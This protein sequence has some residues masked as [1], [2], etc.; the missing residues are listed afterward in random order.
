MESSRPA[1][2]M[3]VMQVVLCPLGPRPL[4]GAARV[5]E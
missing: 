2:V 1:R 5:L 3:Q 4:A